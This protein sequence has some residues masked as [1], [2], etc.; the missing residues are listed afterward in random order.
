MSLLELVSRADVRA[1][2]DR[3][4]PDYQ[5]NQGVPMLV[6]PGMNEPGI[7]RTLGTAFDYAFR[8]E[9][10]RRAGLTRNRPWIAE[11]EIAN[12]LSASRLR[13]RRLSNRLRR[14]QAAVD[15]ARGF[16]KRYVRSRA[17]RRQTKLKLAAHAFRL[18]RLDAIYR[19]G[20]FDTLFVRPRM[21]WLD[22]IVTM[23][24]GVPW[25][26]IGT[27]RISLNPTF[28]P[29]GEAIG[30]D[31]DVIADGRLLELKVKQ[32]PFIEKADIRQV[33]GYLLLARAARNS[34]KRS[35]R[36]YS[37]GIYFARHCHLWTASVAEIELLPAF[38][39]VERWFIA[40]VRSQA[41]LP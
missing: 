7:R 14:A 8:M 21:A 31:A 11:H 38:A 39:E 23:L 25:W 30:A 26:Q 36:L 34:G 24:D 13:S 16:E 15:E 9:L 17:P 6:A 18:A 28:G 41:A 29:L 12:L 2:L 10:Q 37:I 32:H 5:R 4:L 20:R 3:I 33:I 35:P 40:Q 27:S 19:A 22:E 1:Q